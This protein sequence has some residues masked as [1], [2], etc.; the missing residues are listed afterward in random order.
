M[1]EL[2]A[3]LKELPDRI[4]RRVVKNALNDA[5][6]PILEDAQARAPILTGAVRASL[7]VVTRKTKTGFTA[8]VQTKDGDFVG[9][10]F[11][12]SFHEYGS[13]HQP[14]KPFMRPAFDH[15]VHNAIRTITARL[16][17]GIVE[18]AIK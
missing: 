1:K 14:A 16:A 3:M 5:A 6:A 15:N 11:Y 10:E 2:Q 18:A 13:S 17:S 8:R 9:N 12:A 4:E 7:R